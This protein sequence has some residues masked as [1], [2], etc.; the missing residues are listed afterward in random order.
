MMA[1]AI[2]DWALNAFRN[3]SWDEAIEGFYY[4]ME[5]LGDDGPSEF[6][7]KLCKE[8]KSFANGELWDGVV[9]IGK[10]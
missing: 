1:Y 5:I 9:R 8:N 7:I 2:F 10:K 4:A 3:Q 6:Y